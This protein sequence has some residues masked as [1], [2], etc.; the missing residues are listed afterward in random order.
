MPVHPETEPAD[1]VAF[2]RLKRDA[3]AATNNPGS[4]E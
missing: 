2:K 1:A 4:N 3:P